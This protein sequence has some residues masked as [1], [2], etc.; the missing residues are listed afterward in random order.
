M[1]LVR[2]PMTR[3]PPWAGHPRRLWHAAVGAL[4]PRAAH[5]FRRG[6]APGLQTAKTVL[7]AVLA[8]QGCTP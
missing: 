6:R 7:A 8:S 3:P 5:L 4:P 2:A 1:S